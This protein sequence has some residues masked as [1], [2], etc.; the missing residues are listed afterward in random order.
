[1]ESAKSAPS[2]IGMLQGGIKAVV[3]YMEGME[4]NNSKLKDWKIEQIRNSLQS[5]INESQKEWQLYL[6]QLSTKK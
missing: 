2:I 4:D 3:L 5:I 6:N 1:M